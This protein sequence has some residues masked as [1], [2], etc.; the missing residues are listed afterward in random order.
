MRIAFK[1]IAFMILLFQSLFVQ[2]Q[3]WEM[4]INSGHNGFYKSATFNKDY[5]LLATGATDNFVIVWDFKSKKVVWRLSGH[6]NAPLDLDFSSDGKLLA[7]IGFRSLGNDENY[8]PQ[9][10]YVVYIWD[11][12]K[13]ILVNKFDI[14]K[15]TERLRFINDKQLFIYGGGQRYV[16]DVKSGNL[17]PSAWI[18]FPKKN[19]RFNIVINYRHL[20]ITSLDNKETLFEPVFGTDIVKGVKLSKGEDKVFYIAGSRE[21]RFWDLYNLTN[22]ATADAGG[23]IE[24]F[25]LSPSNK[26]LAIAD[27]SGRLYIISTQDFKIKHN[28]YFP[29]SILTA[30]FSQDDKY[31][32]FAGYIPDVEKLDVESGEVVQ[33]EY[34]GSKI[35]DLQ[36]NKSNSNIIIANNSGLEMFNPNLERIDFSAKTDGPQVC[37]Q[38][39]PDSK[40]IVVGGDYDGCKLWKLPSTEVT[41]LGDYP[42]S[43]SRLTFSHDGK[44]LYTG[45][46]ISRI[47]VWDYKK[48]KL[49]KNIPLHSSIIS[50]IELFEGDKFLCSSSQDG[51]IKI[52]DLENNQVVAT[53]ISNNNEWIVITSEGYFDCSTHGGELL[54]LVNNKRAYSVDQFAVKNNRPDLILMKLNS[55]NTDLIKHFEA[56]Y[57]KR[58]KKLNLTEKDLEGEMLLPECSIIEHS[59]EGNLLSLKAKCSDNNYNLKQLNVYV[60]DV[61]IY[62]SN[63]KSINGKNILVDEKIELSEGLNKIEISCYNEKMTESIR[64]LISI[65]SEKKVKKDLYLLAF[66]V[67]KYQ[68]S[69]Y[70]LAFADKDAIDLSKVIET[71]KGKGFENVYTKVLTNEQ[72]TPDAIKV[73]KDFVKNA[74]PDD[75]FI[76]FIA[77]HGMHDT[78]AEATYYYLTSNADINNLKG[79]CADFETIEDL[80]QG[81]PPRNKLFLMD[82]CESGEI[83]D[84]DQGQMITTATGVGIA[85]RGFKNTST[86]STINEQ[87]TTKRSYLYQKDRYIYNDLVRRSGAIVFSSSKG[88]ELS[89]ERSDIEN[90]LFTE[91]IMKALTTTEADK[92][93]NGTVSTDE[94]REY[95]STQVAKASGDLQHPT[96]DRDNI[97]QKFGFTIK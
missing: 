42:R 94:L 74:K 41:K 46:F 78:D 12:E 85:S 34:V 89:Y 97:Y 77:G 14:D 26:Y 1:K 37:A 9:S 52:F 69:S 36:I 59:V 53:L 66:G 71:Y 4:I 60:N 38:F 86:Q 35:F 90:G 54:S 63:G 93:G 31:C 39:S 2:A 5:T 20:K 58:L 95:V 45:D 13:G 22:K 15:Y 16:L 11:I 43:L 57:K 81:I 8:I 83:D 24:G 76:L 64:D 67:S 7:S 75:T 40:Y 65:K 91:Y 88:G 21:I 23:A 25:D 27:Y 68:N 55:K 10:V 73:S 29:Q 6:E 30:K 33:K 3:K 47:M 92:D 70:N 44:Y 72:V 49:I 50:G 80:L 56:L 96:V 62:G 32:F 84:E 18:D 17:T 51:T 82:A 19:E 87:R 48:N 28:I 61:P 79:T